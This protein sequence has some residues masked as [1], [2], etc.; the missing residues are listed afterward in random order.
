MTR[1]CVEVLKVLRNHSDNLLTI[2]QVLPCYPVV[3]AALSCPVPSCQPGH[4]RD[5]SCLSAARLAVAPL[6]QSQ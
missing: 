2:I 6:L 4:W 1:C 3:P 5:T